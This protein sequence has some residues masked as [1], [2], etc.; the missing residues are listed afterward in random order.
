MIQSGLI[1]LCSSLLFGVIQ[2]NDI[3]RLNIPTEPTLDANTVCKTFPDLTKEQL[4][5]CTKFPDVTASAIQGIQIAVHE[6]QHQF[7]R[8]RWNCTSLETKNKNP[9]SNAMLSR[10]YRETAFAYAVSSAGVALSV[11]RACSLGKLMSC[12]CDMN[13]SGRTKDW[14]W[15]G[16]SHNMD[17]G[18]QFSRDFLDSR[19]KAKD[20]HS[21][22]NT[23]NNRAGRLAVS[24]NMEVKCKCHGMS[25]SCELKTCWKAVPDFN[26]V[27]LVLKEKF[28]YATMVDHTNINEGSL[29]PAIQSHKKRPFETDLVYFEK[30]PNFCEYNHELD[31]PGTEGRLCNK[32]SIDI[33]NCSSLCCG[34]GYN[35][36]RQSRVE[37]CNCRF[38]WCC[39]VVCE[40]CKYTE[41][42]T[43]CK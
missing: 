17:F 5:L 29:R 8:N 41:W 38:H 42:V 11:A 15:G 32:T 2:G 13:V 7:K 10:G 22:I 40:E 4:E 35:T 28:N 14:E 6:C 12:G 3:L 24:R 37:R 26:Q 31:S 16:C 1:L 21:Q 33:D 25:G 19:E 43:V 18:I 27:G 34:R 23:H 39:Y 20:I 30:S 36:Q 9:H